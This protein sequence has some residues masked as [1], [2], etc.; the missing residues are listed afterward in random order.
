MNMAMKNYLLKWKIDKTRQNKK[1]TVHNNY[2][3]TEDNQINKQIIDY[4]YDLALK[5]GYKFNH[6]EDKSTLYL[7]LKRK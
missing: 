4:I 2:P 6:N 5:D 7:S 3:K 1:I